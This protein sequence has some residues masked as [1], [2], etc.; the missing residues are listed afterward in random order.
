M[1][2]QVLSQLKSDCLPLTH[3]EAADIAMNQI[4]TNLVSGL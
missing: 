1:D 3:L 4:R 2:F